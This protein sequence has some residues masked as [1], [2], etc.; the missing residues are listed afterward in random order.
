MFLLL[1]Y[2][3]M[4]ILTSLLINMIKDILK[5]VVSFYEI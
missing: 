1:K 4:Q 5:K 2:V 3:E